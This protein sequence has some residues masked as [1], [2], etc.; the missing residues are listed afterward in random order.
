MK[1][2]ASSFA[3]LLYLPRVNKV[4]GNILQHIFWVVAKVSNTFTCLLRLINLKYPCLSCCNWHIL[5]I[6]TT[7]SQMKCVYFLFVDV[8]VFAFSLF[9][10][11]SCD[12]KHF[13]FGSRVRVGSVARSWFDFGFLHLRSLLLILP[14]CRKNISYCNKR[15]CTVSPIFHDFL[16]PQKVAYP[17]IFNVF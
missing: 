7:V 15:K 12:L 13:F 1:S 3:F 6:Y 11:F 8:C 14:K 4:A 16:Q 5:Y 10:L 17:C 9:F 2:Q